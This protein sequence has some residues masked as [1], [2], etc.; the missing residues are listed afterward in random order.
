MTAP[1]LAPAPPRFV[2]WTVAVFAHPSG[3][4]V[5]QVW[6][7]VHVTLQATGG[8]WLVAEAWTD[9][10][11]TPTANELALSSSV[12]EYLDVARLAPVVPHEEL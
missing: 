10:G 12:N 1:P 6:R 9:S 11:P 3:G 2:V 4:M 5:E 7:T 8:R